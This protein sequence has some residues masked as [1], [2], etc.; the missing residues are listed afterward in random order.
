[1]LRHL[2]D[3]PS[4]FHHVR[5]LCNGNYY[6]PVREILRIRPGDRI[7]D[8]GCGT[9]E[10]SVM[11]GPGVEYVGIDTDSG[12]IDYATRMYG[13]AGVTFQHADVHRVD[14][15]FTKAV[16]MCT[17]HH[18][19][20]DEVRKLGD[21]LR[22]IVAGDVAVADPDPVE[23]GRI[24]RMVLRRDRG[25]YVRPIHDHLHLLR[26]SYRCRSV[27]TKDIPRL[28]LA[29]LTYSLCEPLP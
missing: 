29:R 4:L 5:G 1:V 23:S 15:S 8:V 14:A 18:L 21:R 26:A 11:A 3:F 12:Y 9:G 13:R 28:R 7:L 10:G 2:F 25:R 17:L 27:L 6:V 20:D 22:E 19:S 24:Q 16:V